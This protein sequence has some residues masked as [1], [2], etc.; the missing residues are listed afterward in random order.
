MIVP[1]H[2]LTGTVIL[3]W[4]SLGA[5]YFV[6]KR[7]HAIVSWH[8][9][10]VSGICW[11]KYT[12]GLCL[13]KYCV[14]IDTPSCHIRA[15]LDSLTPCSI[16]HS[17]SSKSSLFLTFCPV[18][19]DTKKP[20]PQHKKKHILVLSCSRAYFIVFGVLLWLSG[21]WQGEKVIP[22]TIVLFGIWTLLVFVVLFCLLVFVVFLHFV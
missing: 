3:S 14:V 17:G 20:H 8:W 21:R 7:E 18:T 9:V 6:W 19:S 22:G 10:C 1:I 11:Q 16:T 13:S 15:V 5:T 2:R 12:M 4:N